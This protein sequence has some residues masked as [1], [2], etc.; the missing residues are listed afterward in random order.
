MTCPRYFQD[1]D[2]LSQ[3]HTQ[4]RG[5][6]KTGQNVSADEATFTLFFLR[7]LQPMNTVKG[8]RSLPLQYNTTL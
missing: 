2:T 7:T 8:V 5:Q 3:N 4:H 1:A 6:D